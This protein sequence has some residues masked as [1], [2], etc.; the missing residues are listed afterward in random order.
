M[1]QTL[2]TPPQDDM[3]WPPVQHAVFK[4]IQWA[5]PWE[6]TQYIRCTRATHVVN[7]DVDQADLF[8]HWGECIRET[9][10]SWTAYERMD[11]QDEYVQVRIAVAPTEGASKARE[12]NM[13]TIFTGIAVDDNSLRLGN[14]FGD[15]TVKAFGLG[16]VLDRWMID[17]G[18]VLEPDTGSGETIKLG[19]IPP[20]NAKGQWGRALL[21]NRS[22]VVNPNAETS[23]DSVYLFSGKDNA[24]IWN[25]KQAIEYVLGFAPFIETM[26]VKLAGQVEA[27]EVIEAVWDANGKSV[28]QFINEIISRK[29]GLG[30]TLEIAEA[31]A[32]DGQDLLEIKVFT[33]IDEAV[34]IGDKVFPANA[35]IAA[36]DFGDEYPVNHLI[37]NLAIRTTSINA[38]NDFHVRG[39]KIKVCFSVSFGNDTLDRG[40][41]ATLQEK[42]ENAD[43]AAN[44]THAD[45]ADSVRSSERFQSVFRHFVIPRDFD[46]QVGWGTA[47]SDPDNE[48]DE[49][50]N[51]APITTPN[52]L[53]HFDATENPDNDE[54]HV[55]RFAAIYGKELFR[56][57]PFQK[58]FDY[59]QTGPDGGPVNN[60]ISTAV[61][62]YQ[63]MFAWI[64]DDAHGRYHGPPKADIDE[65][66]DNWYYRLD[67]LTQA[68]PGRHGIHDAH[69]RGVDREMGMEIVAGHNH[70]LALGTFNIESHPTNK[71]CDFDFERIGATVF[72][73]TDAHLFVQKSFLDT[74]ELTK[75]LLVD[76]ADAEYWYVHPSTTVD[77]KEGTLVTVAADFGNG[78]GVL[79]DD[80]S[81]LYSVATLLF[82]WYG[83]LRRAVTIPMKQLGIYANVGSFITSLPFLSDAPEV[84]TVVT[85]VTWDLDRQATTIETGY[86][87]LDAVGIVEGVSP[88]KSFAG[89]RGVAAKGMGGQ[90]AKGKR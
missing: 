76:V 48:N 80:V 51:V 8:Y 57:L 43:G 85:S 54:T 9:D 44:P 61:P 84:N 19:Y 37:D 67:R 21:G 29:Y 40:W 87:Q 11:L 5:D 15:Q 49:L 90:A 55:H 36:F 70:Y 12:D 82:I 58:G 4:K 33:L 78:P 24:A 14:S 62:E 17:H 50:T 30:Y 60:N 59:T 22:S 18:R 66:A 75:T 81:K 13:T 72:V 27:L 26:P 83:R 45:S 39:A 64:Y 34:E 74:D 23:Y 86:Q 2:R 41:L 42:Y 79:R 68:F 7:P 46:W 6:P 65:D 52:G 3:P 69:I 53:V 10:N 89:R 73:E 77:I 20:F 16:H 28:L 71:S 25:A 88:G 31:A 56:D 47:E 35:D 1:S 38:Y 63:P 32:D